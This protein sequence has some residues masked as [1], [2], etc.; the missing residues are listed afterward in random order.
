[1]KNTIKSITLFVALF[2][3]ALNVSAN[4][5]E[6]DPTFSAKDFINP[7]Q[8]TEVVETEAWMSDVD[9]WNLEMDIAEEAVELE[10]WMGD[11]NFWS[12]ET[13]EETVEVE[14]WMND[15]SFWSM[16]SLNN[17]ES[18]ENE[19]EVENWMSSENFWK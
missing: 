11:V 18:N 2:V 16:E 3:L 14:E 13:A 6:G 4:T 10:N 5:P 1:M 12:I 8:T 7:T 19:V 9:F 15:V 17:L